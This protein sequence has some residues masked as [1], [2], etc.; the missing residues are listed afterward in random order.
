MSELELNWRQIEDRSIRIKVLAREIDE[1]IRLRRLA[2]EDRQRAAR[3]GRSAPK[4][5]TCG[6]HRPAEFQPSLPLR[7]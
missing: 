1:A 4:H 3:Q 6:Q 5:C 2:R 7:Y